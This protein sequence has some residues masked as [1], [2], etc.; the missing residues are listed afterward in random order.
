MALWHDRLSR[1]RWD[2]ASGNLVRSPF[3]T[4]AGTDCR[5]LVKNLDDDIQVDP[6][7]AAIQKK[8]EEVARDLAEYLGLESVTVQFLYP[9]ANS[10]KPIDIAIT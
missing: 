4:P 3:E 7:A 5:L 10:E 1:L 9:N 6:R 8:I 2:A